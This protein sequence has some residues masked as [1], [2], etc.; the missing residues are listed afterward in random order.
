[1]KATGKAA[2][3]LWCQNNTQNY[4]N[5]DVKNFHTSW[6]NG[7]AFCALIHNFHPEALNFDALNPNNAL[8]NNKI[9]W[10]VGLYL[11]VAFDAGKKLGVAPLLDPPDML[12][13]PRPDVCGYFRFDFVFFG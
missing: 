5:V 8:E 1:M 6:R 12:I 11:M 4:K 13:S 2:L 3:L 10:L 7:L 9:G